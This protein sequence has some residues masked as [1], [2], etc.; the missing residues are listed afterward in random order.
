MPSGR[1]LPGTYASTQWRYGTPRITPDQDFADRVSGFVESL[2]LRSDAL[3]TLRAG[4]GRTLLVIQ[5][6]GDYLSDE[7][8]HATLAR[9][10]ELGLSLGIDCF[11]GSRASS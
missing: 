10:V 1:P 11:G 9:I 7:I 5:C 8:P 6:L 3:A 2:Q 4:G